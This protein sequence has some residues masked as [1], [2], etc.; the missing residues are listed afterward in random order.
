MK[1]ASV[2]LIAK[3]EASE[4]KPT[5]LYKI[6]CA[7]ATW[8]YTNSDAA[9]EYDGQTYQPAAITRGSADY[10]AALEAAVMKVTMS[11]ITVPA[12]QFIAQNPIETV[13]VEI[14]RIFRDQSPYEKLVVFI[15]QIKTA[16]IK[17]T[18][19][20]IDCV[21]FEFA[22][23]MAVPRWRYQINCNHQVFDAACGKSKAGYKVSA[24]IALDAGKT[25]LTAAAFDEYDDGYFVGGLLE[26]A[27]ETRTIVGHTGASISINYKMINLEDGKTVDAYPGCDG[28]PET[29]RDKYDN[30]IHFFGFPWIP[31]DNP[32]MRV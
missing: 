8:Y 16:A 21:S 2:E 32:A 14:S 3:E 15:G 23:R 13:W 7:S 24:A 28:R 19:A 11:L 6:W 20:E 9:I 1:D 30:I 12:T 27:G 4:R 22:L 25:I 18:T 5:E 10:N 17:G 26:Y 31:E 29:C